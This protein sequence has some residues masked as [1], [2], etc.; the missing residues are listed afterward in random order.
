MGRIANP[1][2]DE[3]PP[4]APIAETGVLRPLFA[5]L[6]EHHAGTG[7]NDSSG[8]STSPDSSQ[9]GTPRHRPDAS[10][11]CPSCVSVGRDRTM[12]SRGGQPSPRECRSVG[13]MP[14]KPTRKQKL[15]K[16]EENRR[17]TEE[18]KDTTIRRLFD[19]YG[20]SDLFDPFEWLT[21][22]GL[23]QLVIAP[24]GSRSRPMHSR[25]RCSMR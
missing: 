9:E 10:K 14:M 15:R 7:P 20:L 11:R 12:S 1:S 21:R 19:M 8:I 6:R 5:R 18:R 13:V 16:R 24:C 4:A 3:S 23:H 17:R 25:A 22:A 2:Y